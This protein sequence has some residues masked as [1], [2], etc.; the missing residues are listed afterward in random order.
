MPLARDVQGVCNGTSGIVRIAPAGSNAPIAVH[1]RN[2]V[3]C[4][5]THNMAKDIQ[6]GGLGL[7]AWLVLHVTSNISTILI[8]KTKRTEP[9]DRFKSSVRRLATEL[10]DSPVKEQ[11]AFVLERPWDEQGTDT[12]CPILESTGCKI[13]SEV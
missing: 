12:A 8:P 6:H 4:L 3:P 5:L 11:H 2:L 7:F 13:L 1:A 10:Y 9:E